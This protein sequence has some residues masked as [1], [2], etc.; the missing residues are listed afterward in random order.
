MLKE[1]KIT[2]SGEFIF[3]NNVFCAWILIKWITNALSES[4]VW[5]KC[6]IDLFLGELTKTI[7]QDQSLS[8]SFITILINVWIW[9][10]FILSRV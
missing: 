5:K 8:E 3:Y 9:L 7:R 10:F 6:L 2:N 4:I 1:K